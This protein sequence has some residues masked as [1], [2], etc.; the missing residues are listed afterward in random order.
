M[1]R[2]CLLY[3]I[4]M[5]IQK[6]DTMKV[7]GIG[8]VKKEMDKIFRKGK[9][10]TYKNISSDER[11]LF[12]DMIVDVAKRKSTGSQFTETEKKDMSYRLYQEQKAGR[13]SSQD[14][15]DFKKLIDGME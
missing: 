6:G 7:E 1:L 8:G 3:Y 15:K 13:I 12:E 9:D 10:S 4:H 14:K 11:K 2:A 5:K